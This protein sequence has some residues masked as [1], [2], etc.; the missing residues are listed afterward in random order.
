M[1]CKMLVYIK[2]RL[3]LGLKRLRSETKQQEEDENK[4]ISSL[5]SDVSTIIASESVYDDNDRYCNDD[6]DSECD[7]I[8]IDPSFCDHVIDNDDI[9]DEKGCLK[10]SEK[11]KE[12]IIAS[13]FRLDDDEDEDI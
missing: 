2:R 4:K 10:R 5:P 9:I 7:I 12:M 13:D 3:L 6:D 8:V 11:M 1:A